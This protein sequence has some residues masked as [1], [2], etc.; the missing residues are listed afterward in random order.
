MTKQTPLV[1][2]AVSI[3]VLTVFWG[4]AGNGYAQKSQDDADS[5][6]GP[7]ALETITVTAEKREKD[8]Q[9]IPSSVTAV[10]ETQIEDFELTDVSDLISLTPNLYLQEY[11]TGMSYF[12]AIRGVYP[13]SITNQTIGIYVDDVPYSGLDINLY[14]IERIE[15]LRGPQGTLYGR[16][17]EAGIINILT[18]KPSSEWEGSIRLDG[19]SFNGYGVTGAVSGPI[20]DHRLGFKVALKYFETDGYFENLYDN[21]DEA[22]SKET[23]D[24]RITLTATPSDKL[25]LTFTA[26][27]QD[28]DSP[29]NANFAP[30]D[31]SDMRKKVNVDYAGEASKDAGGASFRGEYQFEN[32][33]LVSITA[34]H[35]EDRFYSNDID[36]TPTDLMTYD[37]D[38]GTNTYSQEFRLVSNRPESPLQWL[39]GLFLFRNEEENTYKFRMNFMNMGMGVPGETL[40]QNGD[41]DTLGTA[42]FGE[43]TYNF[44]NGLDL[45]LGL[46]YDR[47]QLDFEYSQQLS[48]PT[49]EM[50]GYSDLSMSNDET[51]D[52][53]LPKV[54]LSYHLSEEIM[55]YF[56]ISR[57]FRSGGFNAVTEVGTPYDPEYSWNYELGVKTSW[58]NNKLRLNACLFYIDREDMLVDILTNDG[59]TS[60]IDNAAKAS[61]K[62]VEVDLMAMPVRG[63]SLVAGAAYT[64]AQ[65]EDYTN[66]S[67][68]FDGNKVTNS[69]EYTLNLGA[70]YRF[71][72]GF[73]INVNYNHFGRIYFDRANTVSQSDYGLFGAK[74]GYETE[75]FD[76]YLYGKNIFDQEYATRAFDVS[77]VW[78]GRAGAPQ[79]LGIVLQMRF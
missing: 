31:A 67:D 76:V 71:S 5:S 6:T 25:D 43:A 10:S 70:T 7:L 1:Q 39:M 13:A 53:W 2:L 41:N 40:T 14:D 12:G 24:G 54:A 72:D 58:L 61:S 21:S 50:M 35:N 45:T 69:P 55:P 15:V 16:N 44:A 20:L 56:S 65:F 62:G 48:G 9:T 32:I 64:D 17:S 73:F 29:E 28:Y 42:L 47:E 33:K 26:D 11:G 18:K 38:Q 77:D 23:L 51:F 79:I 22:A 74:I 66:G 78:Y 49:L 59:T 46:R 57:G 60:Y 27:F 37:W 30:L 63:L 52:S 19:E 68:I 36:F 75:Y 4:F 3:F 34:V 8:V